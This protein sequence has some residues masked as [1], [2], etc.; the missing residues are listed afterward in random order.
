MIKVVPWVRRDERGGPNVIPYRE[1]RERR[2]EKRN[3]A[4]EREQHHY[5]QVY[6]A[7]LAIIDAEKPEWTLSMLEGVVV[8]ALE[9]KHGK[10]AE[11]M[12]PDL[13]TLV[14][15]IRS[16]VKS[17]ADISARENQGS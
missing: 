15:E 4:R 10:D 16:Y 8:R 17:L 12:R 13:N 5:W 9:K 2:R 3:E 6:G 14:R 11:K 7:L 1:L